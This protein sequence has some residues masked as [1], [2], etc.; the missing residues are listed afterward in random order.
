M[1]QHSQTVA[2]TENPGIQ[3][4]V[5]PPGGTII[6]DQSVWNPNNNRESAYD[7]SL[8]PSLQKIPHSS[9]NLVI[10][11][12]GSGP[13]Y[14]SQGFFGRDGE[15][16]GLDN[17]SVVLN[18]GS[19]GIVN[20]QEYVAEGSSWSYLDDGSDQGE[21]WRQ[22]GF[23]DSS[24]E[25]GDA[26]LGYGD[27]DEATVVEF[28]PDAG[29]KYP[30]TYFRHIFQATS[31]AD[32]SALTLRMLR[33]DGAAVYL[34]GIEVVRDNV[35]N[36]A[37]F[38]DFATNTTQ[39]E[40]TFFNFSIDPNLLVEGDNLL[41]V[42]V[43]QADPGSSD[44]SFDLSLEATS[45]EENPLNEFGVLNNDLD[46]ELG[47]LTAE[48]LAGPSN[49]ILAFHPDGTF[50]YTPNTNYHGMDSFTY[51]GRD[52]FGA[53][54]TATVTITVIPGPNEPPIVQ[55]KIYSVNEDI[56]HLH[57]QLHLPTLVGPG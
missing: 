11:W 30:T 36:N 2:T 26:Q 53:S 14:R 35:P 50:T 25:Q 39:T 1:G 13:G 31:V 19:V 56:S 57:R 5:P 48:L 27:G 3:S 33:D 4:Y 8:E 17:V 49:G 16:L 9:P 28:G 54:D 45:E 10:Q 37:Q 32:V 51:R 20:R 41:A 38:D 46:P 12:F 15:S 44:V 29:N 43:H 47:P 18:R 42:E 24:W 21:S 23:D 7:M 6:E 22:V 40:N 52:G 55:D 34:N